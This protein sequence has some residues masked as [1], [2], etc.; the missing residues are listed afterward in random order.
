M[1]LHAKTENRIIF[2]LLGAVVFFAFLTSTETQLPDILPIPPVEPPPNGGESPPPTPQPSLMGIHSFRPADWTEHWFNLIKESGAGV[3]SIAFHADQ[4]DQNATITTINGE[5][6]YY[7]TQIFKAFAWSKARGIKIKILATWALGYGYSTLTWAKKA[8]IILS[9]DLTNQWIAQWS[10]ILSELYTLYGDT[11]FAIEPLDEC[12]DAALSGNPNLTFDA[13][14]DFSVKCIGAYRAIVPNL[15]I[16]QTGIPFWD[17]NSLANNPIPEPNIIYELHIYYFGTRY[18]W[19]IDYYE[20]RLTDAKLNLEQEIL[21]RGMRTLLEKGLVTNCYV[22]GDIRWVNAE[23]YLQ[24]HYDIL[25][26][27]GINAIQHNIAP[28]IPSRGYY[29]MGVLNEDSET[30]NSMG[31]VWFRNM[32]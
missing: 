23:I 16:Y 4:Y 8:E 10:R 27:Y 12:P 6:R 29:P 19:E 32:Q 1:T 30:L 25:K 7:K 2:V 31:E 22:G 15:V 17:I 18:V 26:K 5:A 28:W 20:G 24:D 13:W 21:N 14:Y 9:E 3:F 11:L